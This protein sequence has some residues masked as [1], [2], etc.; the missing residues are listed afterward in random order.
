MEREEERACGRGEAEAWAVRPPRATEEHH[1]ED[2]EE[3]RVRG[4]EEHARQVIAGRVHAPE[5]VV[6]GEGDPRE[7]LVVPAVDRREHPAEMRRRE[8]AVARISGQVHVV[9]PGDEAVAESGHETGE[10]ERED[11][12]GQKAGEPHGFRS[13]PSARVASTT[14]LDSPIPDR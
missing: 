1:D 7:G 13:Y 9:V 3:R 4:V 12:G 6:D 11:D 14:M 5:G 2:G 10:R 8:A